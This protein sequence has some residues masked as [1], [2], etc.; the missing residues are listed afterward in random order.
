M[1]LVFFVN[2]KG[3]VFLFF[4]EAAFDAD[5]EAIA[6]F[7][8]MVSRSNAYAPDGMTCLFIS[9]LASF[10]CKPYEDNCDVHKKL[11]L[12]SIATSSFI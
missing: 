7:D 12:D 6:K 9:Y 4:Q 1:F 8:A 3:T 10:S 5:K 2:Y 11:Y